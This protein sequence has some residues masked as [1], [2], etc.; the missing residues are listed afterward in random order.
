LKNSII[1]LVFNTGKNQP[2]ILD[3]YI[4]IWYNIVL[5]WLVAWLMPRGK[6][7]L[8]RAGVGSL[9]SRGFVSNPTVLFYGNI[10]KTEREI[11]LS[12]SHRDELS[13]KAL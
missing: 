1:L 10:K 6:S 5:Q 8:H 12:E 13:S 4:K 9:R 3:K 2:K 7:G 11:T